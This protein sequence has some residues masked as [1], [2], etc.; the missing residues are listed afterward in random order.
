MR[1]HVQHAGNKAVPRD[2]IISICHILLDE[3]K[4]TLENTSLKLKEHID[5]IL[6]HKSDPE[7]NNREE[8]LK[9]AV[10][11][12]HLEIKERKH[13]R[14]IK[15]CSEFKEKRAYPSLQI[16]PTPTTDISS[17]DIDSSDLESAPRGFPATQG[18]WGKHVPPAKSDSQ[19]STEMMMLAES[20][21]NQIINLSSY[22]LSD[23]ER[24][25]LSKCLT[26]VPTMRFDPFTW[27]KDLD[28]FTR[29]LKWRRFFQK[30]DHQR[31]LQLGISMDDLTDLDILTELSEEGGRPGGEGPFSNLKPVSR[32]MPPPSDYG[33]IEIFQKLVADEI[34][35]IVPGLDPTHPNLTLAERKSLD[36]LKNNNLIVIKPSDKGGNTVILD[37]L[38]YVEMCNA[39]LSDSV[40]YEILKN[41]PTPFSGKVQV[42]GIPSNRI[43]AMEECYQEMLASMEWA[44]GIV[45]AKYGPIWRQQRRF[46]HSTLRHFGLGKLSLEP[47]IIEEFKYVKTEM[48]KFGNKGFS[49][50]QII[51]NAVSNVIC[52]ISFGKRF[53]YEDKEFKTMLALMSRGLEISVNSEAI[54]SNVFS[55]LYYL[56]FGPFRE[57]RQIVIDITAFLKRIIEEHKLSLDPEN[58][59]DFIDMYLL[60]INEEQ[61]SQLESS[62][63]TEYLFFYI[64]GDLFIAG[65]DTTTNTLL[66]SLLY[67][68]LHPNVQEKVQAEIDSVI[69]RDRPPSLTDKIQMPFTEATIMEVQRMTV[70]VPLS[71]PHMASESTV[72]QGYTI[73]KGSVVLANLWAV[74][75]DPKVWEKPNDFNPSRF[76]DE[77]G[78]ILKKEAFIPFGIGK[79][80]LLF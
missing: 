35:N 15:D 16:A 22:D 80:T 38:Q 36:H 26:F 67:M 8:A 65:T 29:K 58:P 30:N 66:W 12:F 28:L 5:S 60:H 59:R 37:H 54:L 39:L 23:T 79:N 75:R 2:D 4:K 21:R 46:S 49:P 11:K 32:R 64:I 44:L 52:S 74:H 76:L 57:L 55:W 18:S 47:I 43:A 24:Q 53:D 27:I 41:D 42:A 34:N 72:F 77:H 73:P 7:F 50:F 25:V 48:S 40:S 19:R 78:Q 33:S 3:E 62:F 20:D 13:K 70:V 45:F 56:P 63:D 9:N 61:R 6:K 51:N 17:S 68:C 71:V 69:G 1:R 10:E 31:C 14:F